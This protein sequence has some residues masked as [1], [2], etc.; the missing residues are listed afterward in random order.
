MHTLVTVIKQTAQL[1]VLP[2]LVALSWLSVCLL[3]FTAGLIVFVCRL[4]QISL[5]ALL[6]IVRA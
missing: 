2:P 4:V 5:D 3:V 1:P 6:Q